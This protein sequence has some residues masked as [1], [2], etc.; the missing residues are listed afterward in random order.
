MWCQVAA[1]LIA[2]LPSQIILLLPF[3]IKLF[4]DSSLPTC[5]GGT[6]LLICN[7]DE[8]MLNDGEVGYSE[9][10]TV[11]SEFLV[12]TNSSRI[13]LQC[14]SGGS[15]ATIKQVNLYFYHDPASGLGLPEFSLSASNYESEPGDPLSF[16]VF[17]N[18]KLSMD[19]ESSGIRNVILVI[20][21][22]IAENSG[23]FHIGFTLMGDVKQFAVSEL[24]ISDTGSKL[25]LL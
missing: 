5:L 11:P 1:I 7:S 13:V 8:F 21:K 15:V 19:A 16:V 23:H 24:H 12:W 22:Q 18:Q 9:G 2:V 6:A 10:S 25:T 4:V 17:W 14:I 3:P 20:T